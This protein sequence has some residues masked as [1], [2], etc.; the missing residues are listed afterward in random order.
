MGYNRISPVG[1]CSGKFNQSNPFVVWCQD[2]GNG[3]TI[4]EDRTMNSGRL[5]RPTVNASSWGIYLWHVISIVSII[6]IIIVLSSPNS[7]R[8][9]NDNVP[10][11][12]M[13]GWHETVFGPVQQDQQPV[14]PRTMDITHQRTWANHRTNQPPVHPHC[15]T[16][17]MAH[18]G[19]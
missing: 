4:H 3:L 6:I 11:F 10:G 13:D 9:M 1:C 17:I 5:R 18:S 2:Q 14:R 8:R 12:S 15:P 19:T 16:F 7:M